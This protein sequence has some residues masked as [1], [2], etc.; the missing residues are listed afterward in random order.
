MQA[1]ITNAAGRASLMAANFI[2]PRA[3][4]AI[5]LPDPRRPLE[6]GV[7]CI[8]ARTDDGVTLGVERVRAVGARR[9]SLILQHG[10]SGNGAAFTLAGRSIAHH[11]AEQGFDCFIPDLRGARYSERPKR[12]WGLDEYIEQD[13]PA[14]LRTVLDVTGDSAVSWLGHS[15]GGLLLFFY[16]IEN[17]DAPIARAVT[18]GSAID[19]RAGKSMYRDLRRL[20]PLADGLMYLPYGHL[21]RLTSR[22]AGRGPILLPERINFFRSN[23][24][25]EYAAKLLREFH[26]IPVQLF[27]GLD[28]AFSEHGFHRADGAVRYLEQ[29]HAYR[30]PTLFLG[31]TRDPHCPPEAIEQTARLLGGH[32]ESKLLHFGIAH[33]H[34]DEYGHFD[35]IIGRRAQREVWPHVTEFL[36]GR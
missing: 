4:R 7:D 19:Y 3:S 6:R 2:L 11:L 24:E 10:L 12:P 13:I 35:L 20:L 30:L 28:T 14:I 36:G 5:R 16:V 23:I 18:V 15:L 17:P 32:P 27:K 8:E 25:P 26:H 9:G 31:G 33:G 34:D 21:A 29:V 1:V 22:L